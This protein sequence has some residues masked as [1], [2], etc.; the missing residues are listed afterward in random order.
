M[1]NYPVNKDSRLRSGKVR[2]YSIYSQAG[3]EK[4]ATG[5]KIVRK[6]DSPATEEDLREIGRVAFGIVYPGDEEKPKRK[7]TR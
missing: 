3:K 6:P 2:N 1:G 5:R 4:D 7:K